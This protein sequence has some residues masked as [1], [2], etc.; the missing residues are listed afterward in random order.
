MLYV[1][2][3]ETSQLVTEGVFSDRRFSIAAMLPEDH[4]ALADTTSVRSGAPPNLRNR[5]T[6][7]IQRE[8]GVT[9]DGPIRLLT[10]LSYCGFYFSPLNLYYCFDVHGRQTVAV[11]PEVSNTPWRQ[12]HLHVLHS[13][14][15]SESG[16][17][18]YSHP[19]TFHVSPFMDMDLQYH[20][21]LSPPGETLRVDLSNVKDGEGEPYFAAH[22]RMARRE[23]SR[24]S[25]TRTVV[26]YPLM[27]AQILGS[28]YFQALKLWWKKCPYYPHPKTRS[29]L[30]QAHTAN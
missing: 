5:V 4:L 27:T 12:Q 17:L 10:Q 28:I 25:L 13:G 23:L 11:L 19:K 22:M 24:A 7:R 1:V 20:W 2:L 8:A 6:Q 26:R 18:N 16:R 30:P 29:S 21:A 3:H 14:N 15:Q 9:L